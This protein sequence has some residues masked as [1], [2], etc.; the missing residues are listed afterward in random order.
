MLHNVSTEVIALSGQAICTPEVF[1][2]CD[3]NS[4][5]RELAQQHLEYFTATLLQLKGSSKMMTVPLEI[6]R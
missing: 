5:E 4:L 6:Y 1:R 3:V 2:A